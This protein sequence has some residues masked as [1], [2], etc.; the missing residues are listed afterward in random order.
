MVRAT[1]AVYSNRK[2]KRLL[3]QAKGFVGDRKNHRRLTSNSV[4]QAMAFNYRGRK[5]CKRDFRSLWISR[6]SV[7][8]KLHGLS[9]SKL[10]HGL[11]KVGSLLDRKMLSEL[12]IHDPEGFA[13]V[14]T[15]AKQALA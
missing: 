9:Y 13:A 14:A 7:G 4:L 12:A 10:I 8:A 15:A 5:Q 6:L 11:K 1:N 2:R 3:K